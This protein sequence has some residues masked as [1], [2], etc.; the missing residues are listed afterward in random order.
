M[1]DAEKGYYSK[2]NPDRNDTLIVLCHKDS[3]AKQFCQRAIRKRTQ[4]EEALGL[5][6]QVS[7]AVAGGQA[8]YAARGALLQQYMEKEGTTIDSNNN[9][10]VSKT[11][12]AMT[13]EAL[14]AK[15]PVSHKTK[16]PSGTS[17]WTRTT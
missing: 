14:A 12:A 9:I 5:M 6:R 1:R 7:N 3:K 10:S 16:L 15:T 17:I 2:A 13:Q 8:P 11:P 4:A